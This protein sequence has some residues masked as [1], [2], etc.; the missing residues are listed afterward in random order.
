MMPAAAMPEVLSDADRE[1][2]IERLA[3]LIGARGNERMKSWW[4]SE[5]T[6]LIKLRPPEF[7]EAMERQRG[8]L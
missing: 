3:K 8:L 1:R 5:M 4:N 2:Q 7:V 6:R